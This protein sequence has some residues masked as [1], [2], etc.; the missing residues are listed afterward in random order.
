MEIEE[1]SQNINLYLGYVRAI[2]YIVCHTKKIIK[3]FK[4]Y[5]LNIAIKRSKMVS[6]H[7]KN[8][9]IEVYQFYRKVE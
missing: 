6:D 9:R 3:C 8:N 7:I 4:K 2:S 1:G 5:D